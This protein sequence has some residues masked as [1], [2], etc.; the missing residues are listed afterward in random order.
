MCLGSLKTFRVKIVENIY[1][2]LSVSFVDCFS[3]SVSLT[4]FLSS[5]SF[6]TISD[7]Y[8]VHIF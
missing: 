3:P 7:K 1:A 4:F 8:C 2:Y 6:S 5:A